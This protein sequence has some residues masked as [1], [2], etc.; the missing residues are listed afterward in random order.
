MTNDRASQPPTGEAPRLHGVD[1]AIQAGVADEVMLG[2]RRVVRRRRRRQLALATAAVA[3]M[4]GSFAWVAPQV[5]PQ[6]LPPASSA[7]LAEP[8]C[9]TLPDGSTAQLKEGAEIAVTYSPATRRIVLLRGEAHFEVVPDK[10]RPLVVAVDTGEVRAV[11]TAF[12][13]QR[14]AA[15]VEVLVTHGR[16]AVDRVAETAATGA[17]PATRT[18]TMLDAGHHARVDVADPVGL[19]VVEKISPAEIQQRLAWRVPRLEFTRTPLAEAIAMINRQGT[20]RLALADPALGEVR[21]SGLLRVD[22][23]E[24][25]LRLLELEHGIQAERRADGDVVLRSG[26]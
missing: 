3:I 15:E 23:V 9:R 4:L 6:A 18:I 17:T 13:V 12:S 1:W 11:G 5:G 2:T 16:V 24:S 21:I 25:L 20:L 26:R 14:A 22:N 10:S 7:V 8:A 19:P